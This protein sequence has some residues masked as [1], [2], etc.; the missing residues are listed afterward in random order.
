LRRSGLESRV[1]FLI[2]L[3]HRRE[4][5]V[6]PQ[7]DRMIA[8]WLSAWEEG[9]HDTSTASEKFLTKGAFHWHATS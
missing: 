6:R 3:C 8:V 2:L 5:S 4:D 9:F 1:R 7:D